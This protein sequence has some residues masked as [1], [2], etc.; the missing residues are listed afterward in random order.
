M[1]RY[2]LAFFQEEEL[3]TGSTTESLAILN[4][5][6]YQ[7]LVRLSSHEVITQV[8]AE[9]IQECNSLF[10]LLDANSGAVPTEEILRD[11]H[12]IKGNSGTLGA[13]QVHMLCEKIELKA[14]LCE[15]SQFPV[16]II[17]L[18]EALAAFKQVISDRFA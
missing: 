10:H 11:I 3:S 7:Q 14:K 6:I 9:F 1:Y 18:K 12:T 2:W 13:A 4:P 16:E 8:Y 17:E 5:T 15:F